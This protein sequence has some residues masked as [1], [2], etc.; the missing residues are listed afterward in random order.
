MDPD[1]LQDLLPG[2]LVRVT[3]VGMRGRDGVVLESL[4][5][6][7]RWANDYTVQEL[8]VLVYDVSFRRWS[9]AAVIAGVTDN[10]DGTYTLT[11]DTDDTTQE[12]P[13]EVDGVAYATDLSTLVDQYGLGGVR[14]T[15]RDELLEVVESDV[16]FDGVDTVTAAAAPLVGQWLT[17]GQLGDNAGSAAEDTFA[18][19]G[20]DRWT[21]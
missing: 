14:V 16:P 8:R 20:R 13:Y 9:A 15:I 21:I 4:V 1:N 19:I 17:L 12:Q 18:F 3:L 11:F 7:H 5:L 10:L 6:S 2:S